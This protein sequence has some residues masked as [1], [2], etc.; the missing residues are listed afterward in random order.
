[1]LSTAYIK[2]HGG[3]SLGLE[4]SESGQDPAVTF[5]EGQLQCDE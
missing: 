1:M 4:D 2:W 3:K 5:Q